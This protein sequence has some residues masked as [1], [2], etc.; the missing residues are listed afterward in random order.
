MF[1][2]SQKPLLPLC[3]PAADGLAFPAGKSLSFGAFGVACALLP[4]KPQG[5]DGQGRL[6]RE[7]E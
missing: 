7:E 4:D 6:L 2:E 3:M 1:R 5:R